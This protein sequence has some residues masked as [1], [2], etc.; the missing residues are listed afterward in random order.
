MRSI[1]GDA[2]PEEPLV[3]G[4]VDEHDKSQVSVLVVE[5]SGVVMGEGT[6]TVLFGSGIQ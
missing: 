3:H 5:H 4:S 2:D 6:N 1:I